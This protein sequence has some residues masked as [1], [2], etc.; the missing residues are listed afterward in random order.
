ME[1]N[2]TS[3]RAYTNQLEGVQRLA[4]RLVRGLSLVRLRK[5]DLFSLKGRRLRADLILALKIF[6]DVIDLNL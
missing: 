1:A 5:L 6:I 2:S 3:L 4:T